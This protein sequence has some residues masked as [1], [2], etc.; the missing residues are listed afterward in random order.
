MIALIGHEGIVPGPYLDSV[1]VQTYGVGHTAA[2]GDPIPAQMPAGMPADL[3]AELLRVFDVFRADVARYAEAVDRAI[4][5]PVSQEQFDAAVSF[6]YN[7][8]GIARAAWVTALN[9][10]DT[11]VAARKIMNWN[12][13]PEI[14]PRRQDEQRLFR[15]GV[16]PTGALN[17]WNVTTDRRIVWRTARVLDPETALFMIH[18]ARPDVLWPDE[19]PNQGF[20]ASIVAAILGLFGGRK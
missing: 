7:T 4:T 19:V 14:I 3:D 17:V 20:W 12:K 11:K 2:A 5:V 6:H 15:D 9:A 16:Y 13:P 1:G 8:G 18:Y 10:G